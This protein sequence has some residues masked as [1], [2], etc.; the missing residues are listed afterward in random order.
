MQRPA[1]WRRRELIVPTVWGWMLLLLVSMAAGVFA[2]QHIYTFLAIEKPAGAGI[3]VIEGW[4]APEDMDQGVALIR[5]GNYQRVIT[6]G[7]PVLTTQQF[8]E[9]ITYAAL[10]RDYLVR[11]GVPATLITAM[12]TPLSARDRT[13]LSAVIIRDSLAITGQTIDAI[14]VFSSAVH[15]RRTRLLYQMA[16]GPQVRIG[17]YAAK[18]GDYDPAVWWQSSAGAKT[19]IMEAISWLWTALFFNPPPR[20]SHEEKWGSPSVSAPTG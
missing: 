16:F 14:D 17:V 8:Q 11:K 12:P 20:G 1:L 4:M 2:V 13:Y 18:P 6:S 15:S 7:A 19:V 10:A 9:S 3:L 5:E